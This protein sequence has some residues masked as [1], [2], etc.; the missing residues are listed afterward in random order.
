MA[1]VQSIYQSALLKFGQTPDNARFSDDYF[2]SINDAQNDLC[3]SRSWGFLR[4]S[5]TVTAS[6]STRSTA[7]PTNFGKA[8]DIAGA[9]RILTPAA[10]VGGI[11]EL[12]SYENWLSNE[13]D[14]G[15][16]EGAPEF[17]YILGS[18][19]YFSPIPDVDYTT[20]LIYYKIPANIE[21]TSSTIT[22]PDVYSELLKKMI[23]RRLQD[24]GYASVQE[25]QISDSDIARLMNNAAR[26]DFRRYGGMN[27]SLS[28]SSFTRST[29]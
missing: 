22:V 11:V 18:S 6:D 5:A 3:T 1:T 16:S 9:F 14:D 10:S 13:Y 7:L 20:S 23:W 17:A 8:Y 27:M 21:N 24:A 25:L 29:V 26:D 12:M 28:K 4:T 19:I 2:S 15:T